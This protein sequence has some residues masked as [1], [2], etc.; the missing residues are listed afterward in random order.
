MAWAAAISAAMGVATAGIRS[1][2]TR[3]AVSKS[4]SKI[5]TAMKYSRKIAKYA[6]PVGAGIMFGDKAAK[7]TKYGAA[8]TDY[9]RNTTGYGQGRSIGGAPQ[10][11]RGAAYEY[12][13]KY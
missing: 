1:T 10:R 11:R 3:M 9:I 5:P 4:L 8:A 2:L 13:T 7:V 12:I 6:A